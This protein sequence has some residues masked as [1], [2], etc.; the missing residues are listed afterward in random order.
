MEQIA[1][2][3]RLKGKIC[4]VTGAG[5]GI[6]EAIALQFAK[7]G[8]SAVAVLD[9]D[10]NRG[11][12]VCESIS[13]LGAQ[14]TFILCDVARA[15]SVHTA[16]KT[17]HGMFERIDVLVNNTG[18]FREGTVLEASEADYD[19]IMAVNVKGVFLAMKACLPYM[20]AQ[21]NGSIINIAS[22]AGIAAIPGQ[23]VYNL[24]KAAV[25]MLTKS[26]AVD[27]ATENIRVNCICPGRVHT[28]LVQRI[29]D[30]AEDY[31][32]QYKLMSE[33]RPV[34]HMGRPEDIAMGAVFF[35]SDESAYATGSV[36][37]ID[38]GYVCP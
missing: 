10:R 28:A 11:Q 22:E 33:D 7:E 38:G 8:A 17:L 4:A 21:G 12:R 14:G 6:G 30:V 36:L 26:T 32:A 20:R 24:S 27:F 1:G 18:I 37:S 3:G 2:N 34:K 23:V 25:I 19:A 35:A 16:A 13:A 31:D 29:L 15:D 9:I 5:S